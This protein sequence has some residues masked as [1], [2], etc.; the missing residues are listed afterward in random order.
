MY[1]VFVHG[2]GWVEYNHHKYGHNREWGFA[3]DSSKAYIWKTLSGA[4]KAARRISNFAEII[5][6]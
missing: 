6:C 5:E 4:K 2:Q 3:S 1:K